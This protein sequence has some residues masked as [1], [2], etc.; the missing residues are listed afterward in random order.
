MPGLSSRVGCEMPEAAA[1]LDGCVVTQSE[2][3]ISVHSIV[4]VGG[5][6]INDS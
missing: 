2:G 3:Q 5:N 4:I 6:K 1:G